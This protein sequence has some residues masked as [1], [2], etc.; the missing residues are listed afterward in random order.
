MTRSEPDTPDQ[1]R[2]D[3]NCI[4]VSRETDMTSPGVPRIIVP[5]DPPEFGPVAARALLRLLIST[6]QQR[7]RKESDPSEET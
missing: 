2:C 6:H 1:P 3:Y 7:T 5:P 4:G